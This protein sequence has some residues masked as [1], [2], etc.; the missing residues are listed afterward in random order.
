MSIKALLLDRDREVFP[1]LG[2]IFNVTGHK[3]LIAANDK[4]F[5]DLIDSADID[6]VIL[7]HSDIKSWL[8]S[9]KNDRGTLP[10]FIVDREEEELRLLSMGFSDLNFVRKPF[11]PLELLNKLSYLHKLDPVEDAH[12][13][14]M[15]N[16]VVKLSNAGESKIVEISN[17]SSCNLLIKEGQLLGMDCTLE[18]LASILESE[19]VSVKVKN[20]EDIGLEQKFGSTFEFI[21]TLIERSKPVKVI[22]SAGGKV[23]EEFKPVEE[24]A[25]GV[26]R[27]S[28]F[29]TIPVLLKNVY[30]RIYEGRD[31]RIAFLINPG[32]LDEWSGMSNLV[33]DVI[34]NMNE[35]DAVIM[36]TGEISSVYNA[37]LMAQ[38]KVNVQFITDYSVKR[39]LAESGLKSGRIR[40][41]E[42]FPS[43]SV[44]IGTGHRLRFIPMNFTPSIGGFCLYEEDTGFLF[45]PEILSSFFNEGSS[46]NLEEV[47]LYNRIYIPN[48]AILHNALVKLED[49]NVNRVL[50][51]FGLPYDNFTEVRERLRG[52][53]TGVDYPHV[54]DRDSAIELLNEAVIHV[55]NVEEKGVADRFIEELGRFATIEGGNV[56]DIYV[57]PP[58][59]V[60][61][62]LNTLMLTPGVKPSTV[63]GVLRRL[64]E[65][66]VFI[67]P[68]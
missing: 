7:N 58:F 32:T 68:F 10:F 2:D 36:L 67:N 1:L 50:P 15:V 22:A 28:K 34:F 19:S 56:A 17:T 26:Y 30:L 18:E 52:I 40:T 5:A 42:D 59:T 55:I 3:L 25:E 61:L 53:R 51:R 29:A 35:L 62:L 9:W 64:D 65:A 24:I 47:Y 63:I 33:E 57:E 38:Q 31:R 39:S 6:I 54:G 8:S 66:G 37:F 23:G 41:F 27:V 4:M 49:L 11:N 16:T 46:D 60:E 14:G 21:K 44:T 12:Q 48:G 45:T 43:Y 13:L 20:Y